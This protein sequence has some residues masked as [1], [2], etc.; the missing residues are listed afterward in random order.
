MSAVRRRSSSRVGRPSSR[1]V[2]SA[3]MRLPRSIARWNTA[4][5]CP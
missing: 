1:S 5:G 2:T 3:I 4:R